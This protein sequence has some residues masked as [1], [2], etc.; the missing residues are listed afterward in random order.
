MSHY[1]YLEFNHWFSADD[2]DKKI[3]PFVAK[4]SSKEESDKVLLQMDEFC[5]SFNWHQWDLRAQITEYSNAPVTSRS[6]IDWA[7]KVGTFV[8]LRMI[9]SVNR[10][11]LGVVQFVDEDYMEYYDENLVL[12]GSGKSLRLSESLNGWVVKDKRYDETL[13]FV[14]DLNDKGI[15]QAD[16]FEWEYVWDSYNGEDRVLFYPHITEHIGK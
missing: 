11:Y 7:T 16:T 1:L 8:P 5:D 14:H 3:P 4:M 15:P 6:P 9:P 12:P 13:S 10:R 2:V